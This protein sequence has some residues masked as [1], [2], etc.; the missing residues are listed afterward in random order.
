[1][2]YYISSGHRQKKNV[3]LM[4]LITI[5]IIGFIATIALVS[6]FFYVNKMITT[7]Q[8]NI[9]NIKQ[10]TL[11]LQEQRST[12]EE[13]QELYEKRIV[14]LNEQLLRF[15]PVIIPD[16]MLKDNKVVKKD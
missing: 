8:I 4:V 3:F 1:M 14:V 6:G 5:T 12:S 9:E 7:N 11:Q 16:S 2:K 13:N 10:N 15:E